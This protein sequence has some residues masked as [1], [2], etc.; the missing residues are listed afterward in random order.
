MPVNG[1]PS[2]DWR[3]KRALG[4]YR[5][6]MDKMELEELQRIIKDKKRKGENR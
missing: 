6:P 2:D 3:V 1:L 5:E 4:P